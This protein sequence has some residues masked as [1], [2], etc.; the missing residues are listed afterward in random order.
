MTTTRTVSGE[1]LY[2]CY[3]MARV[4]G[5]EP[6]EE[7]L[8]QVADHYGLSEDDVLERIDAWLASRGRRTLSDRLGW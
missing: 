6:P 8:I 3:C 1:V 5:G 4:Y 7:A 2:E